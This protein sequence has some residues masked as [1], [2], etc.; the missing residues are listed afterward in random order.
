MNPHTVIRRYTVAQAAVVTQRAAS[1]L[2]AALESGELHGTQR[3]KGGRWLIRPECLDAWLDGET[4]PHQAQA[5][6]S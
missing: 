3:V 1:T 4:C 5:V 6:A 2:Y